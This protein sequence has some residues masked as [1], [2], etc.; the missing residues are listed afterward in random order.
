MFQPLLPL[1]AQIEVIPCKICGDKSSGIHYGVITCEG[2]KVSEH[3]YN[4]SIHHFCSMFKGIVLKYYFIIIYSPSCHSKPVC[5]SVF[6]CSAKD[7]L[8]NVSLFVH[9]VKVK[10]IQNFEP[11]LLYGQKQTFL[12]YCFL[13]KND[14]IHLCNNMR[15]SK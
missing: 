2:C 9:T 15:V 5:C 7:T 13:Q 3:P 4:R 8:T 1:L 6:L 12:K 11:L 10:G 14:L